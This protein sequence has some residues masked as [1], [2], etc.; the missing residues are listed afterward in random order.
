MANILKEASALY[1]AFDALLGYFIPDTP[2]HYAGVVAEL[3]EE[4]Q[5]ILFCPFVEKSMIAVLAFRYLPFVEGFCHDQHAG[6][7]TNAD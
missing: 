4:I 2:H 7:I 1:A 3:T 6:F 5:K